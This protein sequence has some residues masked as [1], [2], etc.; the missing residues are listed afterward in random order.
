MASTA[1]FSSAT[2]IPQPYAHRVTVWLWVVAAV[3]AAGY[4]VFLIVT[5]TR[6]PTGAD[7][8]GQFTLQPA[9]K[10]LTAV[11]LAAAA[12]AHP[13]VR[14]RRWL[15]GALLF[16]AL[17]D[18]LLAIPWWEP[19][20]VLGLAA[21]LVAHLCFLGVLVPL[22]RRST[23]RLIAVAVAILACVALLTWFWP[24]LVE[25][26]MA[27]PVVAYIAVLGAMVSTALLAQLPTPWTALGGVCFAASDAMIGISQFVR[28]DQLLAVPIWFGYAASLV[29]ITAGLF[30]GRS[31][32]PPAKPAQ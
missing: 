13:I 11:L 29:L 6:L 17:G 24:R 32:Q 20:F 3:V 21:F 15:I 28:G 18:F 31:T 26:G 27:V 4:G 22:A 5:A 14:E 9:V 25:Q 2:D 19:S 12:C 16:S 7:L 10:A 1:G 30:F 23:P 8:T